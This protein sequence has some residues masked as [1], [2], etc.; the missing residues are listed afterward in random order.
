MAR[1][2]GLWVGG[3]AFSVDSSGP[4]YVAKCPRGEL[5]RIS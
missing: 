4:H 5:T 2:T 3:G 1:E